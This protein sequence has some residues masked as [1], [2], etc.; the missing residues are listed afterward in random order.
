MY[1]CVHENDAKSSRWW[2]L[3]TL[4]PLI[5]AT[6]PHRLT[7]RGLTLGDT[8]CL[9]HQ[10]GFMQ[11]CG[12]GSTGTPLLRAS[13]KTLLP[14]ALGVALM[15]PTVYLWWV[16]YVPMLRT[17]MAYTLTCCH[18]TGTPTCLMIPGPCSGPRAPRASAQ[19]G[20]PT[21]SFSIEHEWQLGVWEMNNT[22]SDA[23]QQHKHG[24]HAHN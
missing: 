8:L 6:H 24:A 14:L 3:P 7:I 23:A 18:S 4:R 20:E 10:F 22:L 17:T 19:R 21:R 11:D 13:L 1:A 16:G 5:S 15:V 2:A 12:Y 9:S